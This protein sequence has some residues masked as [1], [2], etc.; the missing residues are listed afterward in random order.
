[1]SL[2]ICYLIRKLWW[3]ITRPPKLLTYFFAI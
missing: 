1:L 3:A 2:A